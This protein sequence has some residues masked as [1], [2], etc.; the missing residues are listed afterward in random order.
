MIRDLASAVRAGERSAVD[1]VGEYLERSE[2]LTHLNAYTLL[3][4]DHALEA[5]RRIDARL[6]AGDDSG[7]LAG[8]PVALKDLIDQAGFPTTAGSGFYRV[9]AERSA[10]VVERLE[11]AGAIVIGRT[12][13]HEFAYGFSSENDWFGPVRNPWN[14]DTSPGGSS[15]GSAVA[16]AAG[17]APAAIGTDTGGSVRVP[18]AMCG[19]VGLKPT[20]GRGSLHG[21]FPLA[22]SFDTVGPF[23][24]ST[25]DVAVLYRV[26][27]GHDPQ[28]PWS[29]PAPMDPSDLK[30]NDLRVGVPQPWIDDA[31]LP[32]GAW[33]PRMLDAL[34]D[35][36]ARVAEVR[37]AILQPADANATL[38]GGEAAH[39]HR[40]WFETKPYGA[41][42]QQRLARAMQVTLDDY[43]D[44]MRWRAKLQ[45]RLAGIFRT[46]DI[47]VTPT[48][49]GGPKRIGD[50]TIDGV[51]YRQ[52][53]SWYSSLVNAASLPALTLPVR[54]DGAPP[55]SVQIIAPWWREE[56][57]FSVGKAL[58]QN[59][60]SWFVPPPHP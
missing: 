52:V 9:V 60:L 35:A 14:P 18:A 8:V 22:P 25:D 1:T 39:I 49:A 17:M 26:F 16:V 59:G 4:A 10:T 56:A 58:E 42:T 33:F 11:R 2:R 20:H 24:T 45:H 41:E 47:L 40:D 7:L 31:P 46:F 32:V 28:D 5:A 43:L 36:G 51:P 44:A 13:L 37:D 27:A 50:P 53:L 38:V 12:N 6:A 48:V 21:V 23:G 3:E 34:V 55:P 57:L 19:V 30:L 15:G 54:A 29:R